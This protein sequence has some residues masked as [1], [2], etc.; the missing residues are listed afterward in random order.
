MSLICS[1]NIDQFDE[2][3]YVLE[4]L[5]NF[6]LETQTDQLMAILESE[7]LRLNKTNCRWPTFSTSSRRT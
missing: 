2:W 7:N 6:I 4:V 1:F 5:S 3:E